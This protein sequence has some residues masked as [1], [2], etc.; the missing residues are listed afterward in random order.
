MNRILSLLSLFTLLLI[1]TASCQQSEPQPA[2]K[3][4][5]IALHGG[6]GTIS[7]DLPDSVKARYYAGLE[8]ALRVGE[9]VLRDGGTALDAVENVVNTLEDNPLF[10]AG[11]GA[12]FTAEGRHEL[13][14][15]IMDGSTLA[16][17][18]VTGLTTVKNPVSLARIVMQES[19][20]IFFSG[21]GAEE[22]ADQTSVERVDNDYFH[23][24]NRYEQWQ[25]SQEQ[26]SAESTPMTMEK[27]IEDSKFGTV[28]AVALDSEGRLAAATS[29]GGMTN[30]QFGRVGDVPII[31]SG[32][33]ANHVAA[34][35]A[36]GWGEQ[37]MRN[38]SANTIANHMEFTG[39][40]LEEAMNFVVTERLNPGDAGFIGVDSLGN[41]SMQMNTAGM[42]RAS[43]D[44]DGNRTV[45]IWQ[46]E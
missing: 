36:T 4:W 26:A 17:G 38:V 29:T 14:A 12:V 33:F 8:E 21:V 42:F 7:Q 9:L 25:R 18:A 32:T 37:I 46:D 44:A 11:R 10:N 41:I 28:G 20:H 43:L 15:A 35:S 34:V 19:R 6:A 13:D 24:Q 22:Y 30:K 23:T 40:S 45:M 2:Q 3:E 39:S 31:G 27:W 1:V 16:A 5:A